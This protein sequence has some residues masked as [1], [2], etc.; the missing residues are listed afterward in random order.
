MPEALE[1]VRT[2]VR[3]YLRYVRW[4]DGHA[5]ARE[6]IE[7]LRLIGGFGGGQ[8]LSYERPTPWRRVAC[9]TWPDGGWIPGL[10]EIEAPGSLGALNGALL[11]ATSRLLTEHP[12]VN[13]AVLRGEVWQRTTPHVVVPFRVAPGDVRVGSFDFARQTPSTALALVSRAQ[14]QLMR[15][16]RKHPG[17]SDVGA[18]L[19]RA[20]AVAG[21][22]ASAGGALVSLA[23]ADG[24]EEGWNALCG[25]IPIGVCGNAP[26]RGMVKLGVQIDHR[27]LDREHV[28]VIHDYLHREV[29]KL[30]AA[31]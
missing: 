11:V 21:A 27:A 20:W 3:A 12:A 16:H 28:A 13:V 26:V 30:C 2:Q 25:G 22:L 9:A 23:W 4:R 24:V 5:G 7:A 1:E 10:L 8:P 17:L 19:A 29:P 18:Q 6:L 31:S 14:R 15:L